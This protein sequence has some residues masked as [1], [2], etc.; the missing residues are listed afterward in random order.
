MAPSIEQNIWGAYQDQDFQVLGI[1]I[2]N[3]TAS[4]VRS[5]YQIPAGITYPLLLSGSSTAS[6]YGASHNY[7]FVIDSNSVIQY[8]AGGYDEDAIISNIV[9]LLTPCLKGDVNFDGQ[10]NVLDVV[11]TVNFI[12]SMV[13]P[14]SS[15]FCAADF[16]SDGSIN[17]L[18]VIGIVNV[19]LGGPTAV[20]KRAGH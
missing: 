5:V 18:D 19:I 17:V 12:L 6:I 9:S 7:Y 3:G 8:R 10:I 4:Q 1:D 11:L 16:D 2:F 20:A 14:D 13:E 15:Q